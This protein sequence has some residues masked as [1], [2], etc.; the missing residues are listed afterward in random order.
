MVWIWGWDYQLDKENL[1]EIYLK[2]IGDANNYVVHSAA[3]ASSV[4]LYI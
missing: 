1:L 2:T 4:V 3:H